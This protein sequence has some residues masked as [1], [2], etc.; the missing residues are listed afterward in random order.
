MSRKSSTTEVDKKEI[1]VRMERN[2]INA[3]RPLSGFNNARFEEDEISAQF[4]SG[5]NVSWMNTIF[6][7][8]GNSPLFID[9]VDRI[10]QNHCRHYPVS[11]HIGVL[12][13]NADG[14]KASIE[15]RGFKH[16]STCHALVLMHDLTEYA[17]PL[18]EFTIKIVQDR[19]GIIDYLHVFQKA[20]S[21][22]DDVCKHF[23]QYMLN[24]LNRTTTETWFVGYVAGLPV[25]SANYAIDSEVIMLYSG[26]T[27]ANYR[28]HGYAGRLAEAC[29]RHALN[30]VSLPVGMYANENSYPLAKKLGFIECYQMEQYV[31]QPSSN[32]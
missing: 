14:V 15:E 8:N 32:A 12:T 9:K 16:D 2:Y 21:V 29:I 23:E 27:L 5:Y 24:E 7:I 11:W 4:F 3:F 17:E 25:C 19:V 26:A 31:H 20:F 13:A 6:R 1:A 22:P 18:P 10:V 28:R 30:K